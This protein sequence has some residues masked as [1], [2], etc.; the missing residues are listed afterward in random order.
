MFESL[1]QV[2]QLQIDSLELRHTWQGLRLLAID[3]SSVHLPLEAEMHHAFGAHCGHPVA[4]MSS[5][6][7]VGDEQT[8]H[9]LIVSPGLSERDCAHLHL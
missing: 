1:N 7:G 8:L 6:Y 5:L 3:G 9:N 2:L 4:R